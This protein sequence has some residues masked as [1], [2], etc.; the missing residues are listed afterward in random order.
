MAV[1]LHRLAS[2]ELR[3]AYAWYGRHDAVVAAKFLTAVDGAIIRIEADPESH[4]IESGHFRWV[5]VRRFP[6]RLIFERHERDMI[7]VIALA[8]AYRR[9]G[10]W[11][12]RT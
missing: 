10:Y 12:R 9:P 4:P 5:R 7:L 1:R 6:Y 8:H 11:Q 3:A 2:R